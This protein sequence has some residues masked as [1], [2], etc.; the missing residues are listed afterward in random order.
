MVERPDNV[1]ELLVN[2][3]HNGTLIPIACDEEGHMIAVMTGAFDEALKVLKTDEDGYLQTMLMGVFADTATPIAINAEGKLVIEAMDQV[4]VAGDD[5]ESTEWTDPIVGLIANMNRIR[6]QIIA[7]TGEAWGTVTHSLTDIW[8]KFHAAT[9]HQHTG[10]ADDAPQID[11]GT[12][13]GRDDDDHVQ[14]L[15]NARHAVLDHTGIDADTIGEETAGAGVTVDGLKLKDRS[16]VLI[17]ALA[18]DSTGSGLTTVDTVGEIVAIGDVLYMKADGKWWKT[19]ADQ[20]ATMP[21]AGLA[22][23]AAPAEATCNILLLGF[24]RDN[25]WTWTPGKILYASTTA[26]DLTD[27]A[28]AGPGDQVQVLGVAIASNIILFNPSYELVEVS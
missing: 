6:N 28:P 11:H 20:A 24:Y 2:A 14:Y 8:A 13:T 16:A 25:T 15:N 18:A 10:A 3:I 19:D 26:G 4:A 21:G 1:W 23:A 9:G 27:T 5:V 12:T 22:M 17:N 7:I